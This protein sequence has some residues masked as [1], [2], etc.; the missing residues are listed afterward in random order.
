MLRVL[1]VLVIIAFAGGV[2]AMADEF[3]DAQKEELGTIIRDYLMKNPEVLGEAIQEL[4]QRQTQAENAARKNALVAKAAAVFHQNGDLI[5]GNPD[6]K[7]TVVEFFDYN[8]GYCR[9][10]FGD[11]MKMIGEDKDIRLVMKEFPILGA[12]STYAAR[13]ALASRKQGKYWEYHV[14]LMSHE[15]KIDEAAADEIAASV[16]LDVK[17]LKTDMSGDEITAVIDSNMSLA[18]AL[19]IQGTPAFVI[20]QTII[21]GA[22]GYDGLM[23]AVK[24]VRDNG[25]CQLC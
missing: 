12:G 7:V 20:D 19:N 25:G 21:P 5:G 3:S 8:C 4:Q 10:A 2:P 6:G 15:G 23:G 18:V 9:K 1:R 14:A 17:K 13:A 24:Q 11:V 16:G 22:V